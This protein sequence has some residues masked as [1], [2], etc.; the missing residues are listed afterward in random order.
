M[1]KAKLSEMMQAQPTLVN[2]VRAT[3]ASYGVA[4][5]SD[6]PQDELENFVQRI[7]LA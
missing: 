1:A 6:L 7:E 2:V 5:V 4:R 3:L